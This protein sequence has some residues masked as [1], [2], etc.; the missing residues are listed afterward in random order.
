M[1]V[2]RETEQFGALLA[3]LQYL[4]NRRIGV[5]RVAI[6]AAVHERLVD[7]FAKR[8]V[9]R[10][11]QH[12]LRRRSRV[13]D[14]PLAGLA[15][16]FGGGRQRGDEAGFEPGEFG[17]VGDEG[18]ELLVAEQLRREGREQPLE[19]RVHLDQLH[20]VGG[21]QVRAVADHLV[22]AAL[23]DADLLRVKPARIALLIHRL[24]AREELRI[25]EQ[26]GVEFGELGAP[27]GVDILD[28]VARLVRRLDAP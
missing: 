6:V 17:L 27:F 4:G 11:L 10:I 18:I 23:D 21:R 25:E 3:Q 15:I 5:V 2:G 28:A 14:R 22:I 19:L 7:L 26:L 20:L 24:V 9:G 8:A 12:R 16:G 1:R 13:L